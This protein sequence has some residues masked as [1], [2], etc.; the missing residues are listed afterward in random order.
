LDYP[1]PLYI[2]LGIFNPLSVDVISAMLVMAVLLLCSAL[3]SGSEVA[4]FSFSK[5]ELDDFKK[6]ENLSERKIFELISQPKQLLATILI[7]N[8]F[9][10]I[11]IVLISTLVINK[12]LKTDELSTNVLLLIQLVVVS[13]LILLFGEILPK[14]Y[15]SVNGIKVARLMAFPL[16]FLNKVFYIPNKLLLSSTSFIDK[17]ITKKGI[18]FSANDLEH[19]LEL[20]QDE[21]TTADEKKMLEGIVKFG[22]T[23]VKQIMVPRLDMFAIDISTPYKTVLQEIVENGYSRVPVFEETSDNVKGI[24][25]IKDLLPHLEKDNFKWAELIRQ[26][27]FVPENKKIDDLLRDFQNDKIHIAI[28]VD[29]YGGTSGLVTLEDIIE[30]IIGDISD[31]FD[32]DQIVYT[33][34][35]D[36]NYVFEGKTSLIDLYK[37]LKIDGEDF[38]QEKGESDT[39]AGFLIEQAGKI[40]LKNEK[41][42]FKNY[43]FII[44]AADKRRI[45]RIK[46]TIKP[47]EHDEA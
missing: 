40:L 7:G 33:K 20:T 27:F 24:L 19:V 21:D 9:I 38:E 18:D 35:D 3:I 5:K 43:T 29:E 45:K 34:I 11:S 22:N 36:H 31:E 4:L 23:D 44:E 14:V 8:N 37:V 10:N 39:I 42:T 26:P 16:S 1:E 30:E 28:V 32:D 13:F 25:Y 2:I 15:A 46:I 12:W 17:R 47:T 41:V 6:S